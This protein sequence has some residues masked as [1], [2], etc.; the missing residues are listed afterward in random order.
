MKSYS[1]ISNRYMKQNK[2]R[3]SL[4]VM[5]IVLATVLIFAVGTFLLS[6]RDSMIAEKKRSVGDAEF[7]LYNI[8]N[9]QGEKIKNN[10]EVKDASIIVDDNTNYKIDGVEKDISISRGNKDYY[11]KMQTS[12][13]LEGRTPINENE[14]IINTSYKRILNV[15]VGDEITLKDDSENIKV[16]KI[17]GIE[18]G[19]SYVSDSAIGLMGYFD[20]TNLEE[21]LDY[22][23]YINLKSKKNKQQI[24]SKIMGEN[25]IDYKNKSD[26][27]ELLYL[28]GNGGNSYVTSSLK[29]MSIFVIITIMICT[30]VVIYNS[31]NIS[32]IERIRYFGILKAIGATPKQIR[33][34][35]FKEGFLMGII[36]LPLGCIIGFLSLKYGIKIFIGDTLMFIEDFKVG[37]YPSIILGTALLVAITILLSI[38]GPAKKANKISAVDAIRNKNEIKLGKLK[39]RKG[40]LVTK[41][42]GIE[43]NIAYKNIRRTPVRFVV[44]S[45]ALTISIIIFNV[46][47]GF[48][49]FAKQGVLQQ[50]QYSLYDSALSLSNGEMLKDEQVKELE[51]LSFV[52]SIYKYYSEGLNFALPV[53]Y[54]NKDYA[55]K[56]N[57]KEF[58]ENY[59]A[60]GFVDF[61]GSRGYIGGDDELKAIERYIV[62]GSLDLTKLKE[63]GVILL[64]GTKVRNENGDVET[65]RATKYKVGDKIKIPKI[66]D[67][68]SRLENSINKIEEAIKNGDFYELEIVAIADREPLVGNN[69]K[70]GIQLMFHEDLYSR[71][72]KD[73]KYNAIFFSFNDDVNARNDAVQYFNENS[74]DKGYSYMDMGEAFN[75]VES[76]YKQVEFF[77][78]CF[79][80]I[81]S[82]ISVVNIFNTISTNLLLRKREFS[83]LKAIGMTEKQLKKSVLLEG[84]LYGIIA[85]I[86]GGVISAILLAVLIKISAG[87]AEIKY[88]F[89]FIAFGL[90]IVCAVGVT[91]IATVFPM[92]KLKKLTV[93]EGI[94]EEE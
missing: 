11:E 48:L 82:I 5:G 19:T 34:I 58:S 84:T 6:F 64:D 17:V 88:K 46:F 21:N 52:R 91:Y 73:F 67:Y 22:T 51:E 29:K 93:V 41:I 68:S 9:D 32:V 30:I 59:N 37:F 63:N 75:Q 70:N 89:D 60:L 78:Y 69:L 94:S 55:A 80:A 66:D 39:R 85:A 61:G 44:T 49:D 87:F 28:T 26:N 79:I 20:D 83:T 31:F 16:L 38:I 4:T 24:I 71:M 12:K 56:T 90:S 92:N 53:E 74:I 54:V 76:I 62:S 45:L 14:V 18:E 57:S 1:E 2:K 3:T 13:I 36:A 42:F 86:I 81:V 43:G 23:L 33:R 47:Y 8:T 50:Y 27:H 15:N 25:N 77:V 10:A 65:I 40:K 7:V 72:V 35:I